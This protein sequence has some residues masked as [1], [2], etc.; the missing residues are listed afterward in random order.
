MM[1]SS[2]KEEEERG[3]EEVDPP[4]DVRA[5]RAAAPQL[6]CS[7][8]LCS[9]EGGAALVWESR[10]RCHWWER[11]GIPLAVVSSPFPR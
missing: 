5:A 6:P 10:G 3:E 1:S 8:L 11:G 4:P 7:D 9:A 2:E